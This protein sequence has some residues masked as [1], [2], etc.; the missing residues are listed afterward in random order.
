MKETLALRVL[1]DVMGWPDE[2]A[3]KEFRWLSLMS[4]LKY[5]GYQDFLAGVRF[6]ES[7]TNWL[8]QFETGDRETAY[9]FVRDSL[10]Y[11]GPAEMQRLV[12]LFYPD[13][14]E[15]RLVR[16]VAE[17][18]GVPP[19][20]IWAD[21]ATAEAYDR[22]LRAT[23]FIG[24]SEGAR[25]DV[26]RRVN[27]GLISTEQVLLATYI[28]RVKWDDA[29]E[30][31]REDLIDQKAV[32]RFVY[33]IDD[34]TAS[35]TTFIRRRK[36]EWKGKLAAFRRNLKE[37]LPT[38]FDPKLSV[39][40]HH[41]VASH[42]AAHD[43]RQTSNDLRGPEWFPKLELTF[44][45]VLPDTLPVHFSLQPE[46]QAFAEIARKYYDPEDPQ[47]KTKHMKEGGTEDVALG[48]AG[49]GLPVVLEHNTPNNAVSLLWAET[50]G[51]DGSD[52]T[53]RRHPMRPLFRRRQRHTEDGGNRSR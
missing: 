48:F 35:G 19:Y 31:L 18:S 52:G 22:L 41:Y 25:L 21:P 1:G 3:L 27:S 32:F 53:P 6:I 12:E 8:Q 15:R 4:R 10:V 16:V 46:A 34:F 37:V 24:L 11:I 44:G 45:T 2:R 29:L 42:R 49:C 26:F 36:D 14:V 5:D 23:L 50:E 30:K 51:N 47:F 28:D 40:A 39:C 13:I 38:H 17:D 33:L 20:R 43:L 9:A 7:L